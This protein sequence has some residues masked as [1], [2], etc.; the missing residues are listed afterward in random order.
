MDFSLKSSLRFLEA[1]L[2]STGKRVPSVHAEEDLQQ[3][4][5]VADA[6]LRGR[7]LGRSLDQL[8]LQN[9]MLY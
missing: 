1:L 9:I 5:E 4:E 8:E 3:I 6:E 2:P 7:L